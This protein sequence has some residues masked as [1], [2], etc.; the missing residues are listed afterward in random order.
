MAFHKMASGH[1]A[2]VINESGNRQLVTEEQFQECCC[3][4]PSTCPCEETWPPSEWPCGG[5]LEIYS[6]DSWNATIDSLG[7]LFRLK[8]PISLTAST[9]G[10]CRWFGTG[11]TERSTNGGS[12]WSDFAT[13][14][15]SLGLG[16]GGWSVSDTLGTL[17]PAVCAKVN[18]QTPIGNY[19]ATG[20]DPRTAT[21]S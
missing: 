11:L 5:L 8:S 20:S 18:G 2:Y 13:L 9:P 1:F 19:I 7:Y 3:P 16:A 4:A 15:F 14:S 21:V 12:A 10:T 17:G 6:L